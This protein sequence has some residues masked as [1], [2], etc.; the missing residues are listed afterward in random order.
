MADDLNHIDLAL[1]RR[2]ANIQTADRV[3]VDI[4]ATA[5][6]DIATTTGHHNLIQAMINRLFTRQ[7]ELAQL[8][9]PDYGSRLYQLIG[10]LNNNRTRALAEVYIRECLA[11]ESRVEEIRHIVFAPPALGASH[12]RLEVTIAVKPVGAEQELTLNFSLNLAG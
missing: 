9:H 2:Q 10:E 6:R 12:N 5:S 4:Q 11:Q 3:Q 8:G 1:T 7:G